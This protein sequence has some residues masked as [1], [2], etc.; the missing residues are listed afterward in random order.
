MATLQERDVRA[1]L[2][3]VG[4][5]YSLRD[6]DELRAGML[7]G[8]RRLVPCELVSY[9][10]A[11]FRAQQMIAFDDPVGAMTDDAPEQFLR[12]GH[13][14]PLVE[15]FQTAGSDGRPRKWSDFFSRRELHATDIY[16]VAYAPMGVEYQIAFT[17]PSAPELLIGLALNRGK[18]DFSER[19]RTVLNLVRPHLV[20]AYDAARE[21]A[22]LSRRLAALERGMDDGGRGLVI[23][24]DGRI[25]FLS[26]T[27]RRALGG[28]TLPPPL[29]EWL[30][31]PRAG[32]PALDGTAAQPFFLDG[33][34][35][36]VVIRLLPGRERGEP[37]SL[38]VESGSEQLPVD[39]LRGLGLSERQAEVLRLVA[40]G[41][42]NASV[43][44][45]L[46]ISPR[47]VE[48]HLQ[49]IFERLGVTNRSAAAAT[50]W[51]GVRAATAP[52]D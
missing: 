32:G 42:P 21:Y 39:A 11:D 26:D 20:Q 2:G 36:R 27:A 18:R 35:G 38:L 52:P 16:R 48:K 14:N 50:A 23:L 41:E 44:A 10:E 28:D 3:Y 6:L 12:Y 47:T 45:A 1:L 30:L 51:A 7:P 31:E 5:C 13:Q 22:A 49:G 24:A 4:E 33:P 25:E 40:L 9:N 17:L 43:A 8:L 29:L 15:Y 19:D 46:G 37:D 34:S